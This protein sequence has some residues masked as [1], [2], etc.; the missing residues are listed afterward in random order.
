MVELNRFYATLTV[1]YG[2][3]FPTG[4][5]PFEQCWPLEASDALRIDRHRV[6]SVKSEWSITI[7]KWHEIDSS[8]WEDVWRTNHCRVSFGVKITPLEDI[9]F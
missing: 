2:R 7:C 4:L 9:P 3:A 6:S 5:L 8:K 1:P